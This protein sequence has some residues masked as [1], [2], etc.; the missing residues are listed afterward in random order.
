MDPVVPR[1]DPAPTEIQHLVLAR[2]DTYLT[3]R[4]EA[5]EHI[6][7]TIHELGQMYSKL[8]TIIDMHHEMTIRIDEN[9]GAALENVESGQRELAV[10]MNRLSGNQMLILKVF[11]ILIAFSMFFVIF[12]A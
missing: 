7:G 6:E 9:M 11:A 12:V 3:S 8:T 10:Y 1:E 2:Q 5:V 4:A